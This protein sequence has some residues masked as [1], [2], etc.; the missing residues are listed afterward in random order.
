MSVILLVTGILITGV[1][2][3]VVGFGIPINDLAVGQ[4][5]IIAGATALVGG[6]ILIGLAAAVS[7]LSQIAEALKGRPAA[8]PARPLVPAMRSEEPA[9]EPRLAEAP[10]LGEPRVAEP[11]VAEPR[12]PA[13][14]QTEPAA[15]D[16]TVAA[17]ASAIERLRSTMGRSERA[18]DVE[19]APSSVNG[20]Q[21]V[22][23]PAGEPKPVD[24]P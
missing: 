24:E 6:P 13:P 12:M 21:H 17:S 19:A 15:A 11:R 9:G 4:T 7:K 14:R 10:R 23:E 1:G 2:V 3:V 22:T 18:S 20:S 16:P 5:L 8:R